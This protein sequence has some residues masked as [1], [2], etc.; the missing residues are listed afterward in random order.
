MTGSSWPLTALRYGLRRRLGSV[1]DRT[2]EA[3]KDRIKIILDL[4]P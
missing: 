1:S 4:H 3:V 2:M